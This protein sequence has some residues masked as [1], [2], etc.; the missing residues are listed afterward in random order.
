M[1]IYI[2]NMVCN[3]C[4]MMVQSVFEKLGLAPLHISLGEVTVA[5]APDKETM[6][7]LS[8][9]LREI[10]FELMDDRKSKLI[11]QVKTFIIKSIQNADEISPLKFSTRIAAHVNHDYSYVS[12]LFS[13]VE[14]ITI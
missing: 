9:R 7:L 11:E 4:I 6:D 12:K 3:R 5:Q 8:D 1:Q 10:G 13:E 2:K 14:S